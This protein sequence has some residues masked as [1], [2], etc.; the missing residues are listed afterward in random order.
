MTFS[1]NLRSLLYSLSKSF[2]SSNDWSSLKYSVLENTSFEA[3]AIRHFSSFVFSSSSSSLSLQDPQQ[4]LFDFD[5]L[6]VLD[7]L[8]R[9]DLISTLKHFLSPV[10]LY[11]GGC[12]MRVGGEFAIFVS[13]TTMAYSSSSLS[14]VEL[15]SSLESFLAF[16]G[17][18]STLFSFAFDGFGIF[19]NYFFINLQ[20]PMSSS[21][22]RVVRFFNSSSP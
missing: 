11:V 22:D 21:S 9:D 10:G 14:E 8:R 7:I 20:I 19:L 16:K 18:R 12:V 2:S 6:I 17:N 5:I 15:S 3:L 13:L 1:P 4:T